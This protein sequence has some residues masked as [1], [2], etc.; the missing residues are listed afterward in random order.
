M[1]AV[2]RDVPSRAT[3]AEIAYQ[4]NGRQKMAQARASSL[5]GPRDCVSWLPVRVEASLERHGAKSEADDG[6]RQIC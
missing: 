2:V 3:D 5:S 4:Q 1:L 6:R